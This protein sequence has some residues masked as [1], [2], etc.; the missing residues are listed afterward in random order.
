[1]DGE[2]P[3]GTRFVQPV[4]WIIGALL[5]LLVT[6]WLVNLL[7]GLKQ[8]AAHHRQIWEKNAAMHFRQAIESYFTEFR[9]WPVEPSADNNGE[10]D[11]KPSDKA[12]MDVILGADN[13]ANK[14]VNPRRIPFYYTNNPA[15][16]DKKR[17][18]HS[19]VRFDSDGGGE[20]FDSWGNHYR[21]I[22]D[23]D[24]DGH[25]PAPDWAEDQTPIPQ[26]VIVWSPGPDGKDETEDDNITTW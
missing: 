19:G 15:K 6:S 3:P 17:G 18:F 9:K 14:I 24:G 23:L 2:T 13:E 4:I 12:L 20:L 21:V 26:P 5:I 16:G 25:V 10:A 11:W 1:M 22:I 8:R 7:A